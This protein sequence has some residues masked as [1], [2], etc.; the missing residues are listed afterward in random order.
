M[1][2]SFVELNR[3]SS[4]RIRRLAETLS[5]DEMLTRVGQ[6]WTVAIVFAHLAWWDRRVDYVL[7]RTEQDGKLYIP[8]LE[9]AI[10]DIS[11]PLWA[12]IPPR[13]AARIAIEEAE[14]LDRR[15]EAFSPALLEEIYNY[16]IRWVD[17]SLHR[18]E[19]LNEAE[20]ALKKR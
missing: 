13:A 9:I 10:N 11:L 5:D 18:N 3:Q 8:N 7:D 14:A 12:S 6:H 1:D 19:H 20:A 2:R 16:N 17:R 15:L 4:A